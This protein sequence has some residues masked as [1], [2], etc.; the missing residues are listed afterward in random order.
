M[1]D[2]PV[3]VGFGITTAEDARAVAEF[4][5]GVVVGSALVKIIEQYGQSEDLLL[6]VANFIA[7]LKQGLVAQ[8]G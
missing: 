4:A 1:S 7:E 8:A 5:D 2:V 3:G 6:N